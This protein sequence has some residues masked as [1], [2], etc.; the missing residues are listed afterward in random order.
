MN[1]VHY[2]T[3]DTFDEVYD[4]MEDMEAPDKEV[5]FI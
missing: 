1:K 5:K 4:A 2:E 3:Y